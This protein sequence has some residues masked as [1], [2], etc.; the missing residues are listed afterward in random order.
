MAGRVI[1]PRKTRSRE[2]QRARLPRKATSPRPKESDWG[3][4]ISPGSESSAS[5]HMPFERESGDLEGASPWM[6]QSRQPGEGDEPQ[7]LV[8][9][10]E[11]SDEAIVPEKLAN[12]WVTPEEL[13]EERAE[14]D[15]NPVQRNTLRTQDRQ[16]VH[17][18]LVRVGKRAKEKKGERFVN[19]LSYVKVPLLKEAYQRLRKDAATGVDGVTWAE[20]GE[21][22]EARLLDLQ[23]RVQRGSYRPQPVR[24]VYIAKADGR[25]RPLGLPALEDKI[26][27]QAVRMLMEPIYES[28]FI[29]F[30]Y[31]F[32]PGRSPH[33][34]LDAL[35]TALG[36]K[37]NW[38]LDADIRSFFD[39]IDHGWMQRFIEHRIGDRRLVRLLMKWL[40]AGVME[41]GQLHEVKEGTPQGGIISPLLANIFMHYVLDLWAQQW[42]KKRARGE[43]YVVRY[44]D[45]FV[46]GFQYEEDA[47][48]MQADLAERLHAFG[49]ELHPEKTRLIRFGRFAHRDCVREGRRR[50]ETFVFLGFTHICG[51]GQDGR[52]R[53]IRRTAH[54]KRATKLA[55]L[56]RQICVR[57]HAPVTDQYRWLAAVLRGHYGYYGVPGNIR[58]LASFYRQVRE[59]WH[60][61]LQRRSQRAAWTA[62]Q[63]AHFD[64]TFPLP[65]PRITHPHPLERMALRFSFR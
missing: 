14:A 53:L 41:E 43:V 57:R 37:T 15:G 44:A 64:A 45:D 46:L 62:G 29:G 8:Y 3:A 9:A 52:F 2:S 39:T 65:P 61:A 18:H 40:K 54:K 23:D 12:S 30:S 22:L 32:R 59:A 17:T 63:R 26:V 58:A 1:E 19:L 6:V 50:P 25:K 56:R 11:E 36:R 13:V 27:Q 49:L 38:V 34:A 28:M 24:R 48:A 4:A 35:Y 42:R 31:G 7:A 21:S 47:R 5:H 10:L 33:M 16:G 55:S 20:Y 60:R 51:Q